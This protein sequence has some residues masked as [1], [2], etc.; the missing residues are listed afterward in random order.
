M[1]LITSAAFV[2]SELQSEFGPLPPCF[3]PVGNKRL[4]HH[5]LARIPAGE[6]IMLTLPDGFCPGP[7]DS[8]A[9][10]DRGVELLYLPTSLSLG[11]SIV[12]ALNLIEFDPTEPLFVLH[13]DTLFDEL[14][15][16]ADLLGLSQVEDNYEWAEYD[17]DAGL[18]HKFQTCEPPRSELIANGFFS[19][20]APKSLIR[21]IIIAGW[22]FIDGLNG[23]IQEIGLTPWMQNAWYDFGHSQTYYQ[24]KTRM[25]TQRAFND[26]A[27]IGHV[28]R[29]SSYKKFKLA[30]E[31]NWYKAIPGALR[32][33]TPQLLSTNQSD[34]HFSYSIEY[35]HLTALNELYV[36]SQLPA[37]AWN[38]IL[39]ACGQF[40]LDA[41]EHKTC[42]KQTL[43][44][45]FAE[46]TL[47]RLTEYLHQA[48]FDLN[49]PLRVNG[50]L[51]PGLMDLALTSLQYLPLDNGRM[52]VL[53]GD[54]CFSNILY[55]FRTC[56][57]KVIDPRG[58][59]AN[60]RESI[61]GNTMYDVAK[62]AHSVIGLY[63]LI[64]A[65][66]FNAQLTDQQ[67]SFD[68]AVT[69][70][71]ELIISDFVMQMHTL[72]GVNEVQLCAMQIQLFVSMLPLHSDRP[73]R[74]LGFI[75]NAYRLFNRI[76]MLTGHAL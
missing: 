72:F 49:Q 36:F 48:P 42:N 56:S 38:K 31:A 22:D 17:V 62:L 27:I 41:S 71:H 21:Q 45:L 20:S 35:L 25:T 66:Y 46:K 29:K 73:D 43:D 58:I 32:I 16:Q 14:P 33:Y 75:G 40:L 24:S 5:Q 54:F 1:Y 19:F 37:F 55:D 23:Y 39:K 11:E 2:A 50:K 44:E 12:F 60:D 47:A 67:L 61:Y 74:Q 7:Y 18:L 76:L 3:L 30:A 26:M 53:H 69:E 13:G 10:A 65:G 34:S 9:L 59:D 70:Q 15:R 28:V 68:I 52:N 57:I 8:R 6:R 64:I 63:D 4:F 51:Y